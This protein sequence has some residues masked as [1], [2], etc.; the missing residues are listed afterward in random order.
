MR[1]YYPKIEHDR[2]YHIFNRGINGIELFRNNENYEY[3]LK[4][5]E[6]HIHP[7]AET[8]AWA[9]MK[10]HFHFLLRIKSREEISSTS[11]TKI[12]HQYFSNL[13]N[14]YTQAFNKMFDRHGSLFERPF[15][16]TIITNER[17]LKN[18]VVYIHQNPL[19]HFITEHILDYP[20]TS[21]QT[22]ISKKSTKITREKVLGWFDD[23]GNF[24]AVHDQDI[25]GEILKE[26]SL[27]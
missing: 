2:I 22:M 1:N 16:R 26:I 4:L 27:D 11:A 24:K 8:Y 7:I 13:F 3:F 20:W 21:Y 14:A 5:Y 12:P 6:N 19:H 18:V 15:K 25:D 17:Y 9:L 10:N 23:L